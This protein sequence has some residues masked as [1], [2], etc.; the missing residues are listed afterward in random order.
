MSRRHIVLVGLPGAGKTTVGKAVAEKLACPFVDVDAIIVR[1]T[2]MPV[3]RFFAEFGEQ[4]FRAVEKE[5]V[6]EAL[7]HDA[8]VVVPGGGWAA[9]AGNLD[10]VGANALVVYLKCMAT[11]AAKRLQGAGEVRPL[12]SGGDGDPYEK[13]RNLLKEREAFYNRADAEVK[14]DMKTAPQVAEDVVLLARQRAGW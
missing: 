6:A 8:A 1:K 12:M 14:T 9:Q 2:Q 11:T 10:A 4:K 13:M 3:E 7:G 5:A